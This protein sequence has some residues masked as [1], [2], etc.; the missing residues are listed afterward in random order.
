MSK[1]NRKDA[2]TDINADADARPTLGPES[3]VLQPTPGP[4]GGIL[5][6]EHIY[7]SDVHFGSRG[8]RVVVVGV[9]RGEE[10]LTTEEQV[11]E[12]QPGDQFKVRS[13]LEGGLLVWSLVAEA[14]E[15]A[16]IGEGWSES[17][18][19]TQPESAREDPPLI[20]FTSPVRVGSLVTFLDTELTPEAYPAFEP[21]TGDPKS[22]WIII[23]FGRCDACKGACEHVG[24]LDENAV[25]KCKDCGLFWTIKSDLLVPG[26]SRRRASV[27]DEESGR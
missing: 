3:G 18:A 2:A 21:G 26:S 19:D 24:T 20:R 8:C 7:R 6:T 11:G 16:A 25:L 27:S 22:E 17:A 9:I 5:G 10:L 1:A 4:N 15:L 14:K 13:N 23:V 12:L